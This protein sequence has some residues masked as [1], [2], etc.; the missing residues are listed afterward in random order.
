M[1]RGTWIWNLGPSFPSIR[2]VGLTCDPDLREGGIRV[3]KS[4]PEWSTIWDF[5][6]RCWRFDPHDWSRYL[7]S[8]DRMLATWCAG[9]EVHVM[10]PLQ[11]DSNMLATCC[12]H[13]EILDPCDLRSEKEMWSQKWIPILRIWDFLDFFD[14]WWSTD[15]WSLGFGITRLG[16][17]P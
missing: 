10:L 4:D 11:R 15:L 7:G 5:W 14:W 13:P 9:A 17:I 2:E 8:R 12:Y 3:N 16:W 1:R 6:D